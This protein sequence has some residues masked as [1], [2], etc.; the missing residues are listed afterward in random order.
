MHGSTLLGMAANGKVDSFGGVDLEPQGQSYDAIASH[1]DLMM[2]GRGP[3]IEFY[4]SLLRSDQRSLLD[5]ACGT[6]SITLELTRRLQALRGSK[7]LAATGVDSSRAMLDEARRRSGDIRWVR[8][9]MRELPPVAPPIDFAVCCYN[10]LQ[11]VDAIGLSQ[12]FC[13]LRPTMRR[14]GLFAF[15]IYRPNLPYLRLKR[16]DMLARVLKDERG[17]QLEIRE[18]SFFDEASGL[19]HLTWRLVRSGN[20]QEE[21]LSQ[22]SYQMWQ[23][24]PSVVEAALANAGF[25]ITSKYGGLDRSN[26]V[27][28]AKKLVIVSQAD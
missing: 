25:A 24:D 28:D 5:I 2:E 9:D 16:N 18:D 4:S 8:A 21:P 20:P 23:H 17:R 26:W 1:Y 3:H 19:L 11:H 12:V 15:D 14:G 27:A 22:T 7:D 13:S 6:G 10:S